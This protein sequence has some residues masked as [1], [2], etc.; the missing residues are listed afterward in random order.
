MLL[1]RW[2]LVVEVIGQHLALQHK[3]AQA[4]LLRKG[5]LPARQRRLIVRSCVWYDACAKGTS[6]GTY[7]DTPS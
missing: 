1:Q 2:Y 5:D 3:V 7:A 4:P 6:L